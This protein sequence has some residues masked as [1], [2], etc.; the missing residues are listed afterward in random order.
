MNLKEAQ[1][2]TGNHHEAERTF[3][4]SRERGRHLDAATINRLLELRHAHDQTAYATMIGY[5]GRRQVV[6]MDGKVVSHGWKD[7]F[8]FCEEC[9]ALARRRLH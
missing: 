7:W 5:G 2:A 9:R 8:E 4:G 3:L 1:H 6:V